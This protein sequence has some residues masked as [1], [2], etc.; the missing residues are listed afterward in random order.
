[1]TALYG[2]MPSGRREPELIAWRSK[3]NAWI[4]FL[5]FWLTIRFVR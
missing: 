5:E 2:G 1:M 3:K 4:M